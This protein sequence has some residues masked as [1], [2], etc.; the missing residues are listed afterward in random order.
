MV[1]PTL[2]RIISGAPSGITIYYFNI[3]SARGS[4][5]PEKLRNSFLV[6]LGTDNAQSADSACGTCSYIRHAGNV[7]VVYPCAVNTLNYA[8]CTQYK[9]V[10]LLI[11]KSFKSGAYLIG[12]KLLCSLSAPAGEYFISMV[13]MMIV[14]MTAA[15]AVLTVFVVMMLMVMIVMVF[16]FVIMIMMM[17]M[18][19]VV[20]VVMLVFMIVV[21][22]TAGAVFAMLVMV[23]LMLLIVMMMV[24]MFVL[25]IIVVVMMVMLVF[26][27]KQSFQLIIECVLLCHCI[28]ELL[29]C[30]HI[31]VSSNNGS[32]VVQ[33]TESC[34]NIIQPVLRNALGVAEY[35]TACIG[36]LVV[37]E[38][39]EILLIHLALGSVNNSGET[40]ENNVMCVDILYR[41]DN[42]AELANA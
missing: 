23:V 39:T 18:L 41:L 42:V 25:L 2:Y 16:M 36:Y 40:V 27:F 33:R 29:A 35:Q 1:I 32:L 6:K 37:E 20:M 38:F 26:F 31:P 19:I 14:I 21:V 24:M 9:A 22:T 4:L 10:F 28:G 5:Y 12:C 13:V 3:G 7:I 17:F 11:F 30:Q 34:N 8:L 15:G